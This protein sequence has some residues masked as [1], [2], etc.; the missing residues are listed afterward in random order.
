MR[1]HHERW[2]G[3]GYPDGLRGEEIPL[4]ARIVA[5]ADAFFSMVS[6]R[7]YRRRQTRQLALNELRRSAGAGHDARIIAAMTRC[8]QRMPASG[9]DDP[10]IGERHAA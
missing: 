10:Q 7:P 1:H 9:T 5:A 2:D 8:I 3:S 4:E 6:D